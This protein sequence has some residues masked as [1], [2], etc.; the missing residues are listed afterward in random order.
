[1]NVHYIYIY[2]SINN[3]QITKYDGQCRHN[4]NFLIVSQFIFKNEY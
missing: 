4:K 1:M 3:I 2:T